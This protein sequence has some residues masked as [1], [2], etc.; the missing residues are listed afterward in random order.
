MSMTGSRENEITFIHESGLPVA[1]DDLVAIVAMP[2][3][4]IEAVR[5]YAAARWS[6]ITQHAGPGNWIALMPRIDEL[7]LREHRLCERSIIALRSAIP[8]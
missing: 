8:P 4:Y 3:S 6:G 7:R 1:R 5:P 2:S